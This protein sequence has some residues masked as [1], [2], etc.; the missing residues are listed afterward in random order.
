[1][2]N[3]PELEISKNILYYAGKTSKHAHVS[4]V[5]HAYFYHLIT[6]CGSVWF[7]L[8]WITVCLSL[9]YLI[10]AKLSSRNSARSQF[11]IYII[12]THRR[13][14]SKF[15]RRTVSSA[16]E[17]AKYAIPCGYW[18]RLQKGNSFAMWWLEKKTLVRWCAFD[19]CWWLWDIMEG[20]PGVVDLK[21]KKRSL[22]PLR[23][24]K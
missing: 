1:M 16:K 21:K 14:T 20:A 15:E 7:T 23:F 19:Y 24:G 4:L 2:T 17:V 13:Q 9:P 5:S 12:D 18:R 11:L 10:S 3:V 22:A 8:Y 6:A